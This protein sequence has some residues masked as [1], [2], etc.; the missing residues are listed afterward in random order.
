MLEDDF[1]YTL[2]AAARWAKRF[3]ASA[4]L[5]AAVIFVAVGAWM[6]LMISKHLRKE[7]SALSDGAVRVSPGR[8]GAPGSRSSRT[9]KSAS[10]R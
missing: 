5:V 9:T 6:G 3:L 10:S 2:G 4:M 1:S 7:L 8:S